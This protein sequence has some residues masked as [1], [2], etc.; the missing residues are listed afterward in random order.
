MCQCSCFVM[1]FT[2]T[3]PRAV[4]ARMCVKRVTKRLCFGKK[5]LVNPD[6]LKERIQAQERT[7]QSQ[8]ETIQEQTKTTEYQ[9][10]EIDDL[11]I[12]TEA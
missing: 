6:G 7:I 11:R 8:E 3:R 10:K 4:D 5:D 1:Y 2:L 12:A 9:K